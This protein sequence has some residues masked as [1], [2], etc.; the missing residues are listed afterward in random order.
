MAV[1]GGGV[2]QL[3]GVPVCP[4]GQVAGGGVT[5][6]GG[7]PVCPAGQVAGGG[8]TQLGGVP[9]CPAGQVAGG[10]VTQLGGVPVCPAGQVAGGGVTQLGG[11]PVCP[12]GQVAGGGVTQ[13]GGVP[14]CPAGQVAGGGVTQLGGVPVCPAGQVAGGGVTQLGGVPVCPAGQVVVGVSRTPEELP[15]PQAARN[16]TDATSRIPNN[17]LDMI[18][19]HWP[20]SDVIWSIHFDILV[21]EGEAV[22][23]F[24]KPHPDR[25]RSGSGPQ[26]AEAEGDRV[27]RADA[28]RI[29][30]LR[31]RN[32]HPLAVAELERLERA[33]RG[34]DEPQVGDTG[35]GVD[36]ALAVQIVPARRGGE[37]LAH[38]VRSEREV[39][40]VGWGGHACAPI[41][42]VSESQ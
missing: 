11:V 35:A 12:A 25:P 22:R 14:V 37:H 5:Q 19:I 41:L 36:G 32:L 10:G 21:R 1:V 40:G 27:E 26:V 29:V 4:A 2:T 34:I 28:H 38:P 31:A 18:T 13:L 20:L 23:E 15:P 8:V 7:V 16:T 9:V 6:L 17:R 3:G 39:R 42:S 24:G 33:V 30:V